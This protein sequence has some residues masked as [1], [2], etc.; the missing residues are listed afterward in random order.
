MLIDE[1]D[2]VDVLQ[3][4][5]SPKKHVF[6]AMEYMD[7]DFRAL[8]ESMKV[9]ELKI[10][11]MYACTCVHVCVCVC[12]CVSVCVS[13]CVCVCVCVHGFRALPESMK[14]N[15]LNLIP[16]PESLFPNP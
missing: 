16:Q 7:H 14:V 4:V 9:C 11:C 8:M 2:H 6:M 13:V 15:P 3:V 5:V 10:I 12:V 1:V